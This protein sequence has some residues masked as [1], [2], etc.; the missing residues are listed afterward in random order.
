M[1]ILV[2]YILLCFPLITLSQGFNWQ[3]NAR[4]PST[5]PVIFAGINGEYSFLFHSGNFNFLES[6][7]PCCRFGNGDGSG[8]SVGLLLEYW[9]E[10]DISIQ[11][12]LAV[13][14]STGNFS[15]NSSDTTRGG[16]MVTA[17]DFES[18]I[19]YLSVN[20][21]IKF[22]LFDS[23]FFITTDLKILLKFD[24]DG[25]HS[26]SRVSENVP[27]ARRTI[28][29]GRIPDLNAIVLMPGIR[30]GLDIAISR[31]IYLSP[32]ISAGYTVNNIIDEDKWRYFN[33]NFGASLMSGI[34]SK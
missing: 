11:L 33:I 7:I 8:N 4:I 20:P 32:Y 27:F 30:F 28:S 1:R 14:R 18:L 24:A 13:N 9:Y 34:I 21:G 16:N 25:E 2:L 26:E 15:V 3:Y 17:Y 22:R 23:K 6:D 10:G 29:N 19:N 31:G 5:Y 12:G